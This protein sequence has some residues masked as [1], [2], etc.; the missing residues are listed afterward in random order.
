MKAA[1]FHE[2]TMTTG[3][4]AARGGMVPLLI[5]LTGL[6]AVLAGPLFREGSIAWAQLDAL[7]P[8]SAFR[9]VGTIEGGPF[10]GAVI[11]DTRNPQT[12]YRLYEML[13]DESQIVKVRSDHIE[14]KWPDATRTELY[15][16]PGIGGGSAPAAPAAAVPSASPRRVDQP[17][18]E[19]TANPNRERAEQVRP[20][21]SAGIA[22]AGGRP[23]RMDRQNP[24]QQGAQVQD[25]GARKKGEGR[26]NGPRSNDD[27]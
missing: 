20:D 9:L 7:R 2:N 4:T 14:L 3:G 1:E 10:T 12:F 25:P 5:V 18:P 8:Q 23:P 24:N 17:A 15:I 6:V 19:R 16:T 27:N 21:A 22:A 11:D 13:P 26:R